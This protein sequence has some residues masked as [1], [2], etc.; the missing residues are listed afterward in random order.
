MNISFRKKTRISNNGF[1]SGGGSSNIDSSSLRFVP[2]DDSDD[3]NWNIPDRPVK[4]I[5]LISEGD[6]IAFSSAQPNTPATATME[7]NPEQSPTALDILIEKNAE[8][9][10]KVNYLIN[11]IQKLKSDGSNR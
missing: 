2:Y 11:E 7:Y 3:V 5:N 6:V 4:V 8:L 9:E 1:L 10:R